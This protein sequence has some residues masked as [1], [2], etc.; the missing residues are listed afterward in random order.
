MK[1]PYSLA[2]RVVSSSYNMLQSRILLASGDSIVQ[3]LRALMLRLKGHSV[4]TAATLED[5]RGLI[6]QRKYQLVI[7]DVGHFAEP[8][9]KFCEEIKE[10]Y[11]EQKVLLQADYHVFLYGSTCPDKVI[12]NE[13]GP[14]HFINEIEAMLQEAA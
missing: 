11:P 3:H 12:S 5:A 10:I 7:V 14:Q 2:V 8:G 9:V 13:D 1:E 4:D 6:S